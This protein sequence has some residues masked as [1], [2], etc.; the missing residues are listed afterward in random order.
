MDLVA[1]LG[2]KRRGHTVIGH[3]TES[4]TWCGA[5]GQ[6]DEAGRWWVWVTSIWTEICSGRVGGE[7]VQYTGEKK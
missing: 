6:E 1:G 5:Q 7:R 2:Q 4:G 3:G